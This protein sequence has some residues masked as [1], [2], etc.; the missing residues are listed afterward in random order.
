MS[1]G[2]IFAISFAINAALGASFASAMSRGTAIMQQLGNRTK[3]LNAEQRRL[4]RLWQESQN[5]VR[6][7][8]RE[9][10]RLQA[11]YQQ[12]RVSESQYRSSMARIAHDMR[13]A[14]M[15]AEEYRSHLQRL[16]RE[17]QETQ[18]AAERMRAAQAAQA[19]A[20]TKFSMARAEFGSAAATVG[21]AAAPVVGMVETAM[22]FE[23]AMSKVQAITRA[24]DE[25]IQALTATARKLGE[26]TSFSAQQSAEAM[27]YL[28]MAGWNTEQ[29]I[30]GMPGLLALAAA[31]GTDLARTADIVSDDLTAFGMSA[32]QAAHMADVFAV[33]ATRT[34]TNV[35]MIGQTMKYAAPVARAFGATMEET[36][37]LTGIMANAG[38]KSTQA[39][40]SLRAGFLRLAGP[41]KKASKAMDELGIS[42]SDVS[43]Q[44]EEASAALK[45][46]GIDMDNIAGEGSHK[47]VAV[48]KELREKTAG[49]SGEQKLA[50]MQAIFGTE[51]ATGWLNVLEAGPDVFAELLEQME[52]C[53][54]E[55]EKMAAVMMDNAQGALTQFKSAVEGTA[56]SIGSAFL[57]M[58]TQAFQWGANMAKNVS[59]WAKE[60]EE[61]VRT[62]GLVASGFGAAYIGTKGF[63]VLS[64]GVQSVIADMRLWAEVQSH[65]AVGQRILTAATA[66]QAR[67]MALLRAAAS[68][69]TYR[70]LGDSAA[71]AYSRMRAITWADIGG[72][73][74]SGIN[75]GTAAAST[76]LTQLRASMA[77][78]AAS[79]AQSA[80][81][82]ASSIANMAR[83]FSIAGAAGQASA[84]MRGLGTAIA[85]AGRASL[86]AMFSPLGVAIMAI[87]GAA[88]LVYNNW[89]QVGP[90]FTELWERIQSAFSNAWTAI[91]PVIERLQQAFSQ[92]VEALGP[93]FAS[94]Q[95]SLQ[96]AFSR[97]A[98]VFAENSETFSIIM[99][100]L[101][102]LAEV[103]GV[104]LV[105]AIIVFANTSVGAITAAVGI[106]TSVITGIIG[107]LTGIIEFIT[108]VFTGDW[109]KAWQGVADIF[110]SI[111]GTLAGIAKSVLGG[112]SSA[113]NGI[114]STVRGIVGGG[115]GTPVE[116]NAT[117]GIYAKGPFLTTF[118]EDGPEAAIPL[119]GSPRAIGLWK[120]AGEIL[121]IGKTEGQPNISLAGITGGSP[122]IS[123]PSINISLNFNG[124]ADA[125]EVQG[126]VEQAGRSVQKNISDLLEEYM[127][128][129]G[130][131][132][133]A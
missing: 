52:H 121:G 12:G 112:I 64:A 90:F 83:S 97:I 124:P 29:I 16:R 75:A 56:I 23:A 58:V 119:D 100:V 13:Q 86:A 107:T 39:G 28:G 131:R 103:F 15:G 25:Q 66:A 105:G 113:V 44:Q 68:V 65:T 94:L 34:N 109:S 77:S 104:V 125:Q 19:S 18:A 106:I 78:T 21:M 70:A 92:M 95:A 37:A 26:T 80:S 14:G 48:L 116:S 79:I 7:Y 71:A 8:A 35:E 74:R 4:D 55:A 123:L 69:N 120:K 30:A 11:Q 85:A 129:L 42:L 96:G 132:S 98:A 72:R 114:A 31:G 45:S 40:T 63:N 76:S 102:T 43:R 32:D 99:D 133:Y 67:A 3:E 91:Q 41:P 47:M 82:A 61:L 60:N 118:A 101:A 117:G 89:E 1:A 87:A 73:I 53:D 59:E 49:L 62:L 17:M 81:G 54:G 110:S 108:G 20:G 10:Q 38:V 126:A 46:L 130:R 22:Q 50:T 115:G 88:Y 33:T 36:A 24:N 122:S 128:E 84:A 2:K 57:P 27:S 6:G 9:M 93:V 51:A 111:F 5:Q 127:H